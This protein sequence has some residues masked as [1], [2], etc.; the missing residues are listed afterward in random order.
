MVKHYGM[1]VILIIC[2]YTNQSTIDLFV[3]LSCWML[4]LGMSLIIP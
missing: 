2:N 4:I 3:G 1:I